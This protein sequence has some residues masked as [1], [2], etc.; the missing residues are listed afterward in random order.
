M[1]VV[2]KSQSMIALD[3]IGMA[4]A[5]AR[6]AVMTLRPTDRVGLIAFD[7]SFRWIA[8]IQPATDPAAVVQLIGGINASG[9][10]RIYPPL[11]AAFDAIRE[12]RVDRRHIILVTDG[13]SPPGEMPQ[14]LQDAAAQRV[15]MTTVGVGPDINREMLQTIATETGGRAYFVAQP[16]ELPQVVSSET[17]KFKASPIEEVPVRAVSVQAAEVTDGIDFSGVPRLLG[18]VKAKSQAG[19]ETI[20]RTDR[21]EPLL[22]RWQYGLGRVIAFMSDGGSRWAVNWVASDAFGALWPQIVRDVSSRDRD[23]RA[24]VADVGEDELVVS[25]QLFEGGPL[26]DV[27]G[28]PSRIVMAAPDAQLRTLRLDETAPSE[29]ETR[30]RASQTGLYRFA[31]GDRDAPLPVVGYYRENEE[32]KPRLVNVA[33]L[34]DIAQAT[35]GTVNPTIDDMLDDEGTLALERRPLWPYWLLLALVINFTELA[36]RRRLV[37]FRREFLAQA[38]SRL[39]ASR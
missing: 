26:R 24:A 5:A 29:Y 39:A 16:A 23:V 30:I 1:L 28:G 11:K 6:D 33:L 32:L 15:T 13:V 36:V 4:R 34:S 19:S 14:L 37:G 20:L 18:F 21:G 2:D 10:T 12:E 3:K 35:G 7:D 31:S 8:P 27:A 9:G 25:Y 38:P 22:V 17:Q